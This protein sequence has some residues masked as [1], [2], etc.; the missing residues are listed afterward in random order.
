MNCRHVS[1]TYYDDFHVQCLFCRGL[2]PVTVPT[3]VVEPVVVVEE[4]VYDAGYYGYDYCPPVV[5]EVVVVDP[6]DFGDTWAD[7]GYDF[8]E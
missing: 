5:E 1:T 2:I 6:Y 7:T 4:V 8:C 3:M